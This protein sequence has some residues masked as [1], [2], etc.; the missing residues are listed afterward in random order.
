MERLPIEIQELIWR[1]SFSMCIEDIPQA[2]ARMMQNIID[3][4]KE[5]GELYSKG[6]KVYKLRYWHLDEEGRWWRTGFDNTALEAL[7]R[8]RFNDWKMRIEHLYNRIIYYVK[9]KDIPTIILYAF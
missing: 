6:K 5:Y 3:E 7:Y 2:H 8:A 4:V 1:K 9:F